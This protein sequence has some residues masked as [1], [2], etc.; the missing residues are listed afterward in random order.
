MTEVSEI[1]EPY[2][3]L[4]PEASHFK[5]ENFKSTHYGI[6]SVGHLGPKIWYIVCQ[7]I[8][9][10]NSLN[11]FKSLIK[12]CKPHTCPCRFCKKNIA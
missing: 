5:R 10:S 6:Q 12:F 11:L 2:Y 1:K 9:Q 7:N 4:S 3:N 8:R